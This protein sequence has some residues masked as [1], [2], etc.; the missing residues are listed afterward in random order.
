MPVYCWSVLVTFAVL[1][2][3]AAV[4]VAVVVACCRRGCCYFPKIRGGYFSGG[5]TGEY[6]V[7]RWVRG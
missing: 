5:V 4:A 6:K 7:Y 2:V 3:V 1:P